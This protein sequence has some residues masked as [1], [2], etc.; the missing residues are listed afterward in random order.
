MRAAGPSGFISKVLVPGII[1]S[2]VLSCRAPTDRPGMDRQEYIDV[3]VELL[4]ASGTARDS[5]AAAEER[6]AI[7]R[8]HGLEPGDLEDFVHQHADDPQYLASVWTD[9]EDALR[10]DTSVRSP[11]GRRERD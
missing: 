7:L 11:G 10:A 6:S 9:I 5:A 4:R 1:L 8:K 3:Y 2:M